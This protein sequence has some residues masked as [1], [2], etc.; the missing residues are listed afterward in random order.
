MPLWVYNNKKSPGLNT[1][2]FSA[3]YNTIELLLYHLNS[4]VISEEETQMVDH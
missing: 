1:E 2:L 3:I 4:Y